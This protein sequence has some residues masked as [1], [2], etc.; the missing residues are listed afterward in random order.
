MNQFSSAQLKLQ[1]DRLKATVH[2]CSRMKE[3]NG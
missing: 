3:A 2:G 1:I